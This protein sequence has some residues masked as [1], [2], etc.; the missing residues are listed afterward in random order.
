VPAGRFEGPESVQG[1]E[2]S[3]HCL[4]RNFSNK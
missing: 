3:S 2:R 1:R 4:Y